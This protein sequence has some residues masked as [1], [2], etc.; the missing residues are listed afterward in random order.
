MYKKKGVQKKNV[1]K[2]KKIIFM[3]PDVERE[4]Q[5]P[6]RDEEGKCETKTKWKSEEKVKQRIMK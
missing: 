5:R 1:W 4:D 2:V 6:E 3:F